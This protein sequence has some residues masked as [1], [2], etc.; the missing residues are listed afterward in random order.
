MSEYFPKL[1]RK[2]GGNVNVQVDSPNYAT[3]S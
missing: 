1:F 3:K 2:F